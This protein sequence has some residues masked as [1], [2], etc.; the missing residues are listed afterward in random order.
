MLSHRCP[1]QTILPARVRAASEPTHDTICPNAHSPLIPTA[2]ARLVL[3]R[4]DVVRESLE[5][6]G[7]L[8][9][10]VER[11][12]RLVHQLLCHFLRALQAE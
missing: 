7:S 8:A 1:C 5:G 11:R 6:R 3:A 9:K 4:Y 10:A 2:L 12:L